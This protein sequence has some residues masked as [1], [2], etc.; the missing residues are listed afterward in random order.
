[1]KR[2]S[3]ALLL[4]S[5]FSLSSCEVLLAVLEAS[6]EAQQQEQ[7]RQQDQQGQDKNTKPPADG[8]VLNSEKNEDNSKSTI[9]N[10]NSK[11]YS[12]LDMN[13]DQITK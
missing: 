10:S 9:D 2:L 4:I 13:Q 6:A 7:Q 3:I 12:D 8:T 1:M 11:M 5:L